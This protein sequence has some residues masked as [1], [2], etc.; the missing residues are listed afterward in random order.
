MKLQG[1]YLYNSA[2]VLK[3]DTDCFIFDYYPYEG[4]PHSGGL[5]D[6][7]LNLTEIR[8]FGLPV[9]VFVS[10]SHAD[11]FDKSIFDWRSEIPGIRY[12]LSHDV[13]APRDA[14]PEQILTVQAGQ[15]YRWNGLALRTLLST[16]LGVAF[17]IRTQNAVIYHAG[18]LNFWDWEGES[19]A[20]R[21]QME[22]DY[23]GQIDLLR[24]EHIDLAFVP[25]DGRL[26]ET[27]WKGLDY[28]MRVTDTAHVVPIHFREQYE[29]FDWLR[30]QPQAAEY[31]NK[32]QVITHRGQSF[33]FET[34]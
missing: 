10:H 26:E 29:V 5:S 13:P 2:V 8:A 22:R 3:T 19:T 30:R 28:Y 33:S 18:D 14:V 7:R 9:T 15:E 4:Q 32:I 17:F 21:S 20:Y 31:L 16:D 23:K 11:H 25:L 34:K 1:W 6:G 12:V 24:G 27:Y